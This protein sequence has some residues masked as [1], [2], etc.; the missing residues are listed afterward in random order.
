MFPVLTRS[1]SKLIKRC[2]FNFDLSLVQLSRAHSGTLC[3][4]YTQLQWAIIY[5]I[6]VMI[7][8]WEGKTGSLQRDRI[9]RQREGVGI[10]KSTRIGV[11]SKEVL[12]S[13]WEFYSFHILVKH[14][15]VVYYC[16]NL[17]LTVCQDEDEGLS[18]V[19]DHYLQSTRIHQK[20]MYSITACEL[21]I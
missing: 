14:S 11:Q 13:I 9:E 4:C 19:P 5:T 15:T 16:H 20:W 12:Y 7:N 1:A 2:K 6:I 18:I 3:E 17:L 21:H 8:E 10:K